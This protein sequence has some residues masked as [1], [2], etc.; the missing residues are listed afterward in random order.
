[1]KNDH[2]PGFVEHLELDAGAHKNRKI[3]SQFQLFIR[4]GSICGWMVRIKYYTSQFTE[5]RGVNHKEKL[6][7]L[8][9]SNLHQY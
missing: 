7:L 1:M 4:F 8:E 5:N 3:L 6:I 2:A 9:S